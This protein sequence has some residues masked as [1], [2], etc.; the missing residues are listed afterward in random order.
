MKNMVY[1]I[2]EMF[3]NDEERP[4]ALKFYKKIF[5]ID[6]SFR[7]VVDKVEALSR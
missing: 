3:E 1:S 5:R 4:R 7:N 6:A 2:A